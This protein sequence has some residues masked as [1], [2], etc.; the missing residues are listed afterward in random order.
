MYCTNSKHAKESTIQRH[1]VTWDFLKRHP[2]T[3]KYNVN[4]YTDVNLKCEYVKILI[5]NTYYG[6]VNEDLYFPM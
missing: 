6:H 5:Y 2:K 1:P 4:I 3:S